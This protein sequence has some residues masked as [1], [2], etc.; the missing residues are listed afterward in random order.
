MQRL[1]RTPAAKRPDVRREVDELLTGLWRRRYV[2]EAEGTPLT[3]RL[4]EWVH[5]QRQCA[6]KM[7]GK[8]RPALQHPLPRV[9]QKGLLVLQRLP[10]RGE[11]REANDGIEDA[12]RVRSS[13]VRALVSTLA[14]KHEMDAQTEIWNTTVVPYRYGDDSEGGKG[15]WNIP[16]DEAEVYLPLLR[17]LIVCVLKPA[18]IAVID[19]EVHKA[20]VGG[21]TPRGYTSQRGGMIAD[22]QT[23]PCRFTFSGDEHR[24]NVM[25]LP[26][27]LLF[28][29]RGKGPEPELTT[30]LNSVVS[31]VRSVQ[32]GGG[33][34]AAGE[35]GAQAGV[36]AGMTTAAVPDAGNAFAML[37]VG[38]KR[39]REDELVRARGGKLAKI[40]EGADED[41]TPPGFNIELL[42]GRVRMC[43]PITPAQLRH[44]VRA[45]KVACVLD[46]QDARTKAVTT[47]S[48]AMMFHIAPYTQGK[49]SPDY[50]Q[51]GDVM[52]DGEETRR[53]VRG[54]LDALHAKGGAARALIVCKDPKLF[55]AMYAALAAT[56]FPFFS[57]DDAI[58]SAVASMPEL[59]NKPLLVNMTR[60]VA[61]A[62]A[63]EYAR[64]EFC[65]GGD[66]SDEDAR[67]RLLA[68]WPYTVW[69]HTSPVDIILPLWR[70][71]S[72]WHAR[73]VCE[74]ARRTKVCQGGVLAVAPADHPREQGMWS[75]RR[76][77]L[78]SRATERTWLTREEAE[79]A[80]AK[81]SRDEK[82]EQEVFQLRCGRLWRFSNRTKAMIAP[83]QAAAAA[84]A[85]KE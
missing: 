24:C 10:N 65:G 30:A 11:Q 34:A 19:K 51:Y 35:G 3:Q 14:F 77:R 27:R 21:M 85:E 52:L 56:L 83:Q 38:S 50:E 37:R 18:F 32:Y 74:F 72:A 47:L 67:R 45:E 61:A 66:E 63:D 25:Y 53:G 28:H 42:E 39:L 43:S 64:E 16:S 2:W 29:D 81:L 7:G 31:V 20:A 26:A 41:A 62:V 58:A 1:G 71:R 84:A 55:G 49:K 78:Y 48:Q 54:L 33:D 44:L 73:V 46:V 6:Q 75:L 8:N 60:E 36:V 82:A 76:P 69:L 80:H 23:Q 4:G 12:L 40:D 22:F 5:T 79:E 57:P 9:T 70:A 17:F 13:H 15:V 59:G 68:K